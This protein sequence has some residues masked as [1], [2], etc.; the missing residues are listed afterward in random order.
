M[1]CCVDGC[2]EEDDLID[3]Q[4]FDY[5]E[6]SISIPVCERHSKDVERLLR[7]RMRERS[8]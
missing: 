4:V 7:L 1:K 5:D 3:L 2:E 6:V 8:L